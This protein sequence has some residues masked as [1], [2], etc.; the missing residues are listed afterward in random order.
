MDD[1]SYEILQTASPRDLDKRA[2]KI[3]VLIP[4]YNRKLLIEET[5]ESALSQDYPNY[6]IV[7]SDNCSTDGTLEKCIGMAAG[8]PKVTIVRLLKNEGPLLNWLSCAHFSTG[9]YLK[10]L[11]SDDILLK[12]CLSTMA[13]CMTN[14][15]GFA[16]SSC[17][18]GKTIADAKIFYQSKLNRYMSLEDSLVPSWYM[19]LKYCIRAELPVSP[20]A[21]MF[22]SRFFTNTLAKSIKDPS[23][24]HSYDTGAG[25]DL[26]L[27]LE[28]LASYKHCHK[29]EKPLVFFRDHVDS[30]T[31]GATS[32]KVMQAYEEEIIYFI[33][34]QNSP[35]AELLGSIYKLA[36]AIRKGKSLI[37]SF[38]FKKHIA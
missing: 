35:Y 20:C 34:K 32:T 8:N 30:F 16:Y 9:R 6:E 27:Y 21:G 18:I 38:Y 11:F 37:H 15:T 2:P 10:V 14:D 22:H 24:E 12:D 26:R 29:I 13:K 23:S 4:V 3:S 1:V 28:A 17:K 33:N 7:I 19:I 36:S 31:M 25:P 5:L